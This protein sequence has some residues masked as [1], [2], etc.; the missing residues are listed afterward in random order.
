MLAS[1]TDTLM[2]DACRE[3]GPLV[4]L[5]TIVGFLFAFMLTQG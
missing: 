3:G 1:L 5:A 2:P 4:A